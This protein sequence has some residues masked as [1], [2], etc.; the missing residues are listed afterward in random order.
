VFYDRAGNPCGMSPHGGDYLVPK[1]LT[2]YAGVLVL[3]WG[4]HRWF[5]AFDGTL[6]GAA[7]VLQQ[8]S[9]NYS[10]QRLGLQVSHGLAASSL[11]SD[12]GPLII[13]TYIRP[14][15][16]HLTGISSQMAYIID[17]LTQW[18]CAFNWFG[19]SICM[20]VSPRY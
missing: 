10:R 6:R 5:R 20:S 2:V 8:R 15:A 19:V 4:V 12:L 11:P 13:R 18:R 3:W 9:L 17:H 14:M 1:S 7:G 16:D